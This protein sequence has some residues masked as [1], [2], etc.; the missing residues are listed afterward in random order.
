M[1]KGKTVLLGITGGIAAYKSA[2]LASLLVK[3]GANVRALMTENAK[4]FINPITFEALTGHKCVSDTFDRNFEFQVEHVALDFPG[5]Q[6]IVAHGGF[7]WIAEMIQVAY[8]CQN[9]SLLPDLFMLN[10]PGAKQY[11]T[12]ANYILR[13]QMLFGSAYPFAPMKEA[14]ECV[15]RLGMNDE[16]K[17]RFFHDNAVRLLK[18]D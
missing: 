17:R 15:E 9:V 3:A 1:L 4:N 2:S 8:H 11:A 7:P 12:A 5:L 10:M 14:V 18:L 6:I 13:D 16:A